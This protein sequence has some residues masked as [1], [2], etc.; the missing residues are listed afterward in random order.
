MKTFIITIYDEGDNN[1]DFPLGEVEV[2][3]FG[4]LGASTIGD[5]MFANTG[6]LTMARE[7]FEEE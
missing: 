2:R 3:A 5:L 7:E 4:W 1:Y 6:L